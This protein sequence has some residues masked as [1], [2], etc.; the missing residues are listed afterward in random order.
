MI[1]IDAKKDLQKLL[2]YSIQNG[3]LKLIGNTAQIKSIDIFN[4]EGK[5]VKAVEFSE[6]DIKDININVLDKGLY[7]LRIVGKEKIQFLKIA[8]N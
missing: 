6:N 4:A 5:L 1:F 2:T 3:T 8:K 7:I